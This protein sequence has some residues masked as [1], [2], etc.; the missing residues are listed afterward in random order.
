ML[1]GSIASSR[2]ARKE[3]SLRSFPVRASTDSSVL[4]WLIIGGW[5]LGVNRSRARF[6]V[7]FSSVDQMGDPI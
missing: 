5:L 3:R 1:M 4:T 7:D 6:L 2:H